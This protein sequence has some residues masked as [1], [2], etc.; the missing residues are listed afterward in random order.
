M[1]TISLVGV[2]CKMI[3]YDPNSSIDGNVVKIAWNVLQK[4]SK[5]Q[6]LGNTFMD[7][8]A[9]LKKFKEYLIIFDFF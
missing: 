8:G 6:I 7:L 1:S 3:E 5:V 2:Y 4:V 9:Y